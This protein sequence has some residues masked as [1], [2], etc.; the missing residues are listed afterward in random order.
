MVRDMNSMLAELNS[1][2]LSPRH[3]NT[4]SDEQI[5]CQSARSRFAPFSKEKPKKAAYFLPAAG[6]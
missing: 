1:A 6:V 3:A 2:A 4:K 5:E